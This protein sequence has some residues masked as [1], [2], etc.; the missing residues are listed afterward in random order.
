[1]ETVSSSVHTRPTPDHTRPDISVL[2][3][4][5]VGE[6]GGSRSVSEGSLTPSD[7]EKNPCG[8]VDESIEPPYG[9]VVVGAAFFVQALIVGTINSFGA[10]QDLYV[11]DMYKTVSTSQISLVGCLTPA[12]MNL[13]GLFTGSFADYFG[14]RTSALLGSLIMTVALLMTS[15]SSQLWHLYLTQGALYGIGGSL[16]FLTSI[17]I[18]SQWFKRRRGLATGIAASGGG[19]GG[20]VLSPV[21]V[22]LLAKVGYR[23]TVSIMSLIHL[24][25]LLPAVALFRCR[26]ESGRDRQK[27]MQ[28]EKAS[29]TPEAREA[30]E[31]KEP[32]RRVRILDFSVVKEIKFLLLFFSIFAI[33]LSYTVP[34]FYFPTYARLNGVNASMSSL[35]VGIINGG[36]GVGRLVLGLAGDHIGDVN[37]LV[38]SMV[39]SSVCIF[40]LWIF[41]KSLAMM[42][43]FCFIYGF[44]AGSCITLVPNVAA[45]LCGIGR[46]ASVCGIVF[47]GFAV[48]IL[49]GSPAAGYF[50]DTLGHS[51]NFLPLQLWTG[52][53]MAVS[54]IIA[55]ALKV[56]MDRRLFA[57]V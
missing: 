17:T 37:S 24:V 47:A 3:D 43:V 10:Y 6:K 36:M 2:V 28:R 52:C 30:L 33:A 16:A 11:K 14:Y 46:L 9:W 18:P 23:W 40:F 7:T 15:V 34:L 19:A 54:S 45:H 31:A 12:I 25:V 41:A 8:V 44:W 13:S 26:I 50:L 53:V 21:I 32:L 48:G 39:F 42:V 38:L 57:K 27:R 55:I 35:L 56:T 1:M 22:A 5:E 51:T 4:K 49:V 20:L 29:M